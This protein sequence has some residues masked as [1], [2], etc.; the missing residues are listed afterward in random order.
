MIVLCIS[1]LGLVSAS[2]FQ[3]SDLKNLT[4]LF[5]LSAH[6]ESQ[7]LEQDHHD[8]HHHPE[9]ISFS[10]KH[11][12]HSD[13]GSGEPH[14]HHLSFFPGFVAF[15]LEVDPIEFAMEVNENVTVTDPI[16]LVSCPHKRRLFRPPIS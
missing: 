4:V 2:F 13:E 6:Q 16:Q 3:N 15:V 5:H 8:H 1:L 14:E 11:S 10:H 9:K 12:N 7:H